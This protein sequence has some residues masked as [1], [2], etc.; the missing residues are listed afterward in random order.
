MI[1]LEDKNNVIS[2][3]NNNCGNQKSVYGIKLFK[4]CL[5]IKSNFFKEDNYAN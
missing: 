4:T 3:I 2:A 1:L 5:V